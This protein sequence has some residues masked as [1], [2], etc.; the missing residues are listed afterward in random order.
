MLCIIIRLLSCDEQ[1][2][3]PVGADNFTKNEDD[4]WWDDDDDYWAFNDV[5]FINQNEGPAANPHRVKRYRQPAE[6]AGPAAMFL[7][8]LEG[9][10][11]TV[12]CIF[13]SIGLY[14]LYR[15]YHGYSLPFVHVFSPDA[16]QA[17]Q[18][19][20]REFDMAPTKKMPITPDVI[21]T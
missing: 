18:M 10:V 9:M 11:Y 3:G 1:D 15:W 21:R 7:T 4:G 19:T 12:G 20:A 17:N 16:M 13:G 14:I 6:T 5:D 2:C 8:V